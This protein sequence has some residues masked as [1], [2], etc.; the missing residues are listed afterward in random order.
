MNRFMSAKVSPLFSFLRHHCERN[1]SIFL[2]SG[3]WKANVYFRIRTPEICGMLMRQ[4]LVASQKG[5]L[6]SQAVISYRNQCI[7]LLRN[8]SETFSEKIMK[9]E[10]SQYSGKV[11]YKC[12]FRCFWQLLRT[13]SW[14]MTKWYMHRIYWKY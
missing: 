4:V 10:K 13:L 6:W 8:P 7:C 2:C 9:D 12:E 5:H 11:F 1:T 3:W 14:E